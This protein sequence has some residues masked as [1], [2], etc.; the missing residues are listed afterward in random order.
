MPTPQGRAVV[1]RT[2]AGR[3]DYLA[4]RFRGLPDAAGLARGIG[5]QG[6]RYTFRTVADEIGDAPAIDLVMGHTPTAVLGANA[7]MAAIYRQRIG[8]GR[9]VALGEHVRSWLFQPED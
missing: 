1:R 7:E 5:V 3:T 2:D 8:C 4:R 6:L 9:T